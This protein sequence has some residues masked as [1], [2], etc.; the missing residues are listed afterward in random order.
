[1][2]KAVDLDT[3]SMHKISITNYA[4]LEFPHNLGVLRKVGV[5]FSLTDYQ[6]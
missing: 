4:T 2:E 3:R 5:L 1:M 6:R